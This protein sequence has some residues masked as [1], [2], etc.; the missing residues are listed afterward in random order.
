MPSVSYPLVSKARPKPGFLLTIQREVERMPQG[1]QIIIAVLTL[2]FIVFAFRQGFKVKPDKSG[3]PSE[4]H[5][6]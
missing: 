2:A 3:S 5:W 6:S 4:Q 1:I